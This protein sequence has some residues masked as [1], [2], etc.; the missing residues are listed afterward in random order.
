MGMPDPMELATGLEKRE[1]LAKAAGIESCGP[2]RKVASAAGG[3]RGV[4][5]GQGLP[6]SSQSPVDD[7]TLL[8]H[9]LLRRNARAI[10]EC[11]QIGEVLSRDLLVD[12]CSQPSLPT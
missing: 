4:H 5:R 9:G 3:T 6:S 1:L 10:I 11:V 8:Y 7:R 2:P 12:D